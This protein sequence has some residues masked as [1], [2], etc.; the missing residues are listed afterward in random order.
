MAFYQGALLAGYASA[1]LGSTRLPLRRHCVVPA[2]AHGLACS[3]SCRSHFQSD[4]RVPVTGGVSPAVWLCTVLIV[5]VGMHSFVIA[6]MTPTLQ[7]WFCQAGHGSSRDPYFL[8]AISNAGSLLSLL[9]DPGI[10]EPCLT[11]P[12]QGRLWATGTAVLAVLLLACAAS[13]GNGRCAWPGQVGSKGPAP[14]PPCKSCPGSSGLHHDELA[15]GLTAYISTDL[16]QC[17]C[18]GRPLGD[19]LMTFILAS[20]Q[21]REDGSALPPPCFLAR[22]SSGI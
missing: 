6:T 7:R 16:R 14:Y 2:C 3:S 12:Q 15:A 4:L 20:L 13:S 19:H 17:P 18:S 8:Y 22:G 21:P 11:L 10:V 1:H 5:S 9:A